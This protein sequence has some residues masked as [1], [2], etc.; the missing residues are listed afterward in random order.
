[1]FR[2]ILIGF[3]SAM[4]AFLTYVAMQPA[5]YMVTRTATIGAPPQ[6]VFPHV[7]SFRKWDAWSPWAKKDPKAKGEHSGPESGEGASFAWSGNKDVGEGRMTLVESKPNERVGIKL[8]FTTPMQGTSHATI[9]LKPEGAGTSVTWSLSGEN[10][11]VG[12]AIMMLM[13]IKLDKMIGDDYEKGL[14]N[15]KA[16]VEA[17]PK[18]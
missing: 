1:M 12:R 14:A 10:G 3:V 11:F 16:V 6:A 7:N 2:N 13:G 15:L 17:G 4:A 18:S 8:D 9:A 5:A